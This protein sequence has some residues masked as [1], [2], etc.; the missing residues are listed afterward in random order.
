MNP[1][2]SPRQLRQ[3]IRNRKW[4]TPYLRCR[5]RLS[6]GQLGDAAGRRSLQ[7]P[8]FLC[9]RNP[10]T[11]S[12]FRCP[13]TRPGRAAHC[14]RGPTFAKISPA[15]KFFEQGEFKTDCGRCVRLFSMKIWSVF[16]WGCSFSF[17]NA[18]AGCRFTDP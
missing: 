15:I 12:N 7:L 8:A 9:V 4:T 5:I 3:L 18:H 2:A 6:T 17:E 14:S 11:L 1:A 16:C 13:R 10:Q